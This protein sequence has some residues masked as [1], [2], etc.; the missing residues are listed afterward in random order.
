M[1][2]NEWVDIGYKRGWLTSVCF[3]HDG[4]PRLTEHEAAEFEEY[5]DA[6]VHRFVVTPAE[7]M[8]S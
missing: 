5:D 1:T 6:C 3:T 4:Y 7:K 2:R 8:Q